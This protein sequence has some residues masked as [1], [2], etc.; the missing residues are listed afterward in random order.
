LNNSRNGK[1]TTIDNLQHGNVNV[2]VFV[3]QSLLDERGASVVGTVE[4]TEHDVQR[5]RLNLVDGVGISRPHL[6]LS[7]QITN[8][9]DNA[10]II[11]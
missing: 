10:A 8:K 2:T 1:Q 6:R 9:H 5:W 4:M 11:E 7:K 3:L